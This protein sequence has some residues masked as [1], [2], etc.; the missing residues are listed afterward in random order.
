MDIL[1]FILRKFPPHIK[2][3]VIASSGHKGAAGHKNITSERYD[4][5]SWSSAPYGA[6]YVF[7]A[8]KTTRR[9]ITGATINWFSGNYFDNRLIVL[10]TLF[11]PKFYPLDSKYSFAVLPEKQTRCICVFI[12][13]EH[14]QTPTFT[15]ANNDHVCE[16]SALFIWNSVLFFK[17]PVFFPNL[18]QI[19]YHGIVSI[20]TKCSSIVIC[21]YAFLL[22]LI[23]WLH[24][25]AK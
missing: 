23:F 3:F 6:K 17:K 19:M 20:Q 24:Y 9:A 25:L 13:V 16:C 11:N 15:L 10:E 22:F 21:N 4:Q 14:F 1:S 5:T 12:N 2:R 18:I 8:I 7:D